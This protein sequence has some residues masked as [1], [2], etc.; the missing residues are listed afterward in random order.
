MGCG[1][2]SVRRCSHG[3][4]LDLVIQHRAERNQP[5]LVI[6]PRDGDIDLCYSGL[7]DIRHDRPHPGESKLRGVRATRTRDWT[8]TQGFQGIV[9]KD[10][11]LGQSLTGVIDSHTRRDARRECN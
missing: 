3:L 6:G 4:W 1:G 11:R 5:G 8:S 7:W 10:R 2:T 9:G